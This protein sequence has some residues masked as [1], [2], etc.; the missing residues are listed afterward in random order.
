MFQVLYNPLQSINTELIKIAQWI[1]VLVKA[2]T[3]SIR[4]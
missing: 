4:A 1:L 2:S 3:T